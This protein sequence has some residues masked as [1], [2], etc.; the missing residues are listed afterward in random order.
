MITGVTNDDQN[1]LIVGYSEKN[2]NLCIELVPAEKVRGLELSDTQSLKV[3][4]E[5]IRNGMSEWHEY[6]VRNLVP[7]QLYLC[8]GERVFIPLEKLGWQYTFSDGIIYEL[9]SPF[10]LEM[11]W[12]D[13]AYDD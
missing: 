4:I 6:I 9:R 1:Y 7:E 2:S 12:L 13:K 8:L 5:A 3:L 11:E 10:Q